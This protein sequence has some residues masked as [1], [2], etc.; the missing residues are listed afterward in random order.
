MLLLNLITGKACE[1]KIGPPDVWLT[2][3][4]ILKYVLL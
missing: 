2:V 1:K 4:F 3:L